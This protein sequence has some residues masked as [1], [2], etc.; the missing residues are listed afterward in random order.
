M[1]IANVRFVGTL[2]IPDSCPRDRCGRL[3]TVSYPLD[4][5]APGT[6]SCTVGHGG[7]LNRSPQAADLPSAKPAAGICRR[8]GVNPIPEK[9]QRGGHRGFFCTDCIEDGR[10]QFSASERR[11]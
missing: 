8:C 1:A 3:V 11:A 6:W 4:P 10:R 7:A 5:Q 9:R 2:V